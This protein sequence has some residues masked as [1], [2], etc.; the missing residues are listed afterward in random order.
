MT[1]DHRNMASGPMPCKC[2]VMARVAAR[3]ATP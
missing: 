2:D 1:R 3:E